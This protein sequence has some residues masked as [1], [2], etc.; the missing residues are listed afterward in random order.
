MP[1]CSRMP[2][3]GRFVLPR[4]LG[5][6]TGRVLALGLAG[7]IGTALSAQQPPTF[8]AQIET[9]QVDAF[10]TD[11]TGQPVTN[12]RLDDFEIL[13]DGKTQVITSFSEVSIPIN[14][15]PPFSPTA[16]RPDV[17]T[18]GGTDGRLYVI[19]LD[20]VGPALALRARHFLRAF[21]ERHFEPNDVGVV[22]SVGR[23]RA[24]AAQDFT[25]DRA[26]LIAAIDRLNGWA[27]PDP[28]AQRH[29]AA[30]LKAL[31]ASLA[32]IPGRKALIYI[33]EEVGDVY[34]VVDYGGGVRLQEFDD[35]RA[36]MTDAM[37]GGVAI[38]TINPCG[39]S[40]GGALGETEAAESSG[41]RAD[42]D[43]MAN[44]RA[45]SSATG[46]FSVVNSNRIDEAMEQMVR[47][48]SSYYILGFTSTNDKR[49]GGYRR[50]DVRARRPGLTVRARDGYIA[51]SRAQPRTDAPRPVTLRDVIASPIANGAVPMTA[52]A[53]AYKGPRGKDSVVVITAELDAARLDLTEIEGRVRGRIELTAAAVSA[54]GKVTHG[55]TTTSELS[56]RPESFAQVVKAGLRLRS[57]MTL[58]PGRYQLRIAA[59]NTQTGTIGSVMYDLD[60]PEFDKGRMTMSPVALSTGG[61]GPAASTARREFAAGTPLSLYVEVYD[62]SAGRDSHTIELAADLRDVGGLSMRSARDRRVRTTKGTETFFMAVPL[63]VDAGSYVL[64]VEATTGNASVSRDIPIAVR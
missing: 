11:R 30:A 44:L 22:V 13:E 24:G 47:E 49:D 53:A 41:C 29:R 52:F 38:Y 9:I 64:H 31:L 56:L 46:G 54:A 26:L 5:R 37:R 1:E 63:D 17:A 20:T 21:I 32:K 23:A 40:P 27:E 62:N 16:P 42:L 45:L 57:T 43:G 55:A 19:A 4:R 50:L 48:N 39:L 60:V 8:R 3:C 12:L 59:G 10:V 35:L 28:F 25:S 33:T 15:P 7:A 36:A 14:P 2:S 18:N 6:V 58:V 51:P 34:G 61:T